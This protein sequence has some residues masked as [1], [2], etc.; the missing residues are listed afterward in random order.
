MDR[1]GEF[2]LELTLSAIKSVFEHKFRI[3]QSIFANSAKLGKFETSYFSYGSYDW[4][5]SL[6]PTG[7]ADSQIGENKDVLEINCCLPNKS[8]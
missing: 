1:N 2:Q 3:N 8:S 5:L 4:S 6:Y 7:R